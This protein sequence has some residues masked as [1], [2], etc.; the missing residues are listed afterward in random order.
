MVFTRFAILLANTTVLP[1]SDLR[2]PNVGALNSKAHK[3][4]MRPSSSGEKEEE[5]IETTVY[6]IS[7]YHQKLANAIMTHFLQESQGLGWSLNLEKITS[8]VHF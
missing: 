7:E 3:P 2:V 6:V 8:I 4:R 1:T 5:D